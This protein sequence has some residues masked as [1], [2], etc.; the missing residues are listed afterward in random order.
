MARDNHI[1]R[2]PRTKVPLKPAP[3]TREERLRFLVKQALANIAE[4]AEQRQTK[5]VERKKPFKD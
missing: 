1:I 2:V 5:C 3:P 4:R